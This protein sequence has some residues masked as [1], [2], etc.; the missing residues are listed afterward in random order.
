MPGA[1]EAGADEP[2]RRPEGLQRGAGDRRARVGVRGRGT[3]SSRRPPSAL[4]NVK[5][6]IRFWIDRAG[7]LGRPVPEPKG[8]RLMLA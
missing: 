5:D 4:G 6:A 1:S 8:E 2:L 7:E 3:T